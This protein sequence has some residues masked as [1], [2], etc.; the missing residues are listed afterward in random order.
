MTG[1]RR[2]D[3]WATR[4]RRSAP[5]VA[6]FTGVWAGTTVLLAPVSIVLTRGHL[7][8]PASLAPAALLALALILLGVLADD[9]PG[10]SKYDA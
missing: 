2:T 6:T 5:L 8:L 3:R 10:D 1:R 4:A 9:E 7:D